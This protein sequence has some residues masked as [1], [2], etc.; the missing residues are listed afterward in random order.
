[1]GR[2]VDRLRTTVILN[3]IQDR[4]VLQSSLEHPVRPIP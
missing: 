3:L 2:V 4:T 1:V